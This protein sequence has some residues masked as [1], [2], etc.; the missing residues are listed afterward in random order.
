MALKGQLDRETRTRLGRQIRA[1]RDARGWTQSELGEWC[2]TGKAQISKIE[3]GDLSKPE[4]RL[5][6]IAELFGCELRFSSDTRD[7]GQDRGS[8]YRA[9]VQLM[10]SEPASADE[11]QILLAALHGYH[12]RRLIQEPPNPV[13]QMF[14]AQMQ[15]CIL[16]SGDNSWHVK[17]IYNITSEERLDMI[18]TRL[19]EDEAAEGY[20]VRAFCLGTIPHLSPLIIGKKD[21]FLAIEDPRYYRVNQGVHLQGQNSV[22]VLTDYF[23]SLW[24]DRTIIE[25][26]SVVGIERENIDR[27]RKQILQQEDPEIRQFIDQYRVA[28]ESKN[29]MSHFWATKTFRQAV[30]TYR[31]IAA[32]N[33]FEYLPHEHDI[34]MEHLYGLTG[35]GDWVQ[36]VSWD[37]KHEWEEALQGDR[38]ID[39]NAQAVQRGVNVER[40]FLYRNSEE[41]NDL[42]KILN[43]QQ[44]KGIKVLIAD[45]T[46][47]NKV[48]YQNRLIINTVQHGKFTVYP[49]HNSGVF[50]K[51][52]VSWDKKRTEEFERIYQIIRSASTDW[53]KPRS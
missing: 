8:L 16:S 11:R 27:L 46:K 53:A 14:D 25:I 31:L 43:W 29:S 37:E 20:E 3:N 33:G 41:L 18:L 17:I 49:E 5:L 52:Y 9:A 44:G 38:Y 10:Q 30:D 45:T 22:K 26:R 48:D 7:R 51:A 6:K 42:T 13:F 15:K 40:I 36:A 23:E 35:S 32:S 1:M 50:L 28:E 39:F 2:G 21:A 24:N 4:L 34:V 47:L 12:S 19:E